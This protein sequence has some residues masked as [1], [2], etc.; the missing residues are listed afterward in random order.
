MFTWDVFP[1][2]HHAAFVSTELCAEASCDSTAAVL[3]SPEVETGRL[4]STTRVMDRSTPSES[5]RARTRDYS[6]AEGEEF[7]DEVS[8]ATSQ[9]FLEKLHAAN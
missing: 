9:Q 6:S 7:T 2:Q 3:V 4:H 5:L 8:K 1:F